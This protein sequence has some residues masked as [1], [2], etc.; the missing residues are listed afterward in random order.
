MTPVLT[1]STQSVNWPLSARTAEA[2]EVMTSLMRTMEVETRS[3]AAVLTGAGSMLCSKKPAVSA[4][5]Q[6]T[7]R[8]ARP[9][10][11]PGA[12]CGRF[13]APFAPLA[14][15]CGRGR[16]CAR[17]CGRAAGAV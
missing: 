10:R 5:T 15:L 7:A 16:A 9:R 11:L 17:L 14:A 3:S 13:F 6:T 1:T 8:M 2:L 12:L 4:N